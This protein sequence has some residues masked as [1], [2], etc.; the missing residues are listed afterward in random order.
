MNRNRRKR[1]EAVK[2][3]LEE[4][5]FELEAIQ[6]EEEGALNNMPESL[7]ES[8][9]GQAMQTAVDTI[10]DVMNDIESVKDNLDELLQG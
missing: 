10:D 5:Y 8:E 7:Q 6:E 9:R 2:D 1:L 4:L 3:K